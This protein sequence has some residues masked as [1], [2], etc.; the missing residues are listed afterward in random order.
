MRILGVVVLRVFEY[1]SGFFE[2]CSEFRVVC[3]C[4]LWVVPYVMSS[5]RDIIFSARFVREELGDFSILG[6][7]VRWS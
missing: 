1:A 4:G 3:G 7:D 5:G 2:V 6:D